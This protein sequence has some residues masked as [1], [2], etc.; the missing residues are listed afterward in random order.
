MHCAIKV[1]PYTTELYAKI[2]NLQY[3]YIYIYIYKSYINLK[4]DS[5]CWE[6][7]WIV[8]ISFVSSRK[9]PHDLLTRKKESTFEK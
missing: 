8:T 3:V 1:V 5:F 4:P 7:I 9:Y 2:S 6:K